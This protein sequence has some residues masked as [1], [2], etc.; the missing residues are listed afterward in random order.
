MFAGNQ[1]VATN[2]LGMSSYINAKS[3][4]TNISCSP[5]QVCEAAGHTQIKPKPSAFFCV[6]VNGW[7]ELR[8]IN[9]LM[10]MDLQIYS[11]YINRVIRNVYITWTY[12]VRLK[13]LWRDFLK[14]P[15]HIVQP[16]V[17]SAFWGNNDVVMAV[18]RNLMLLPA[19][20]RI[21]DLD[22]FFNSAYSVHFPAARLPQNFLMAQ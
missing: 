21:L 18:Y 17:A 11:L 4:F 10:T 20:C 7:T 2:N 13:A 16:E 1:P 12:R 5:A 6:A 3:G 14:V 8:L 9:S 15:V 22:L 19:S